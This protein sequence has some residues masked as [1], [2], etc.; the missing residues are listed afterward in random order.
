MNQC[1]FTFH[2]IFSPAFN[3]AVALCSWFDV[4]FFV[5]IQ[6]VESSR[7]FTCF[8]F[9]PAASLPFHFCLPYTVGADYR[10]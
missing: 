1:V 6:G 10:S 2:V 4:S 7:I 5:L 9:S 3:R 8:S